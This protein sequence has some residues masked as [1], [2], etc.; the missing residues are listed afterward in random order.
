MC[1]YTANL[2]LL[3]AIFDV[4]VNAY[5]MLAITKENGLIQINFIYIP[6]T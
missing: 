1:A 4:L 3:I 2:Q 6:S 5:L